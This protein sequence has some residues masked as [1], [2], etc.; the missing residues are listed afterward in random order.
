MEAH[1]EYAE[2]PFYVVGESYGGHYAPNVA[3]R[4]RGSPCPYM[5]I[6]TNRLVYVAYRV[7]GRNNSPPF[8]GRFPLWNAY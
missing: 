2:L 6:I 3:Y 8:R 1:P 4:V 5:V 7:R